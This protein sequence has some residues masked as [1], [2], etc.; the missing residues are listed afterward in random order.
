MQT[1][2]LTCLIGDEN[3]FRIE[4]FKLIAKL[5]MALDLNPVHKRTTQLSNKNRSMQYSTLKNEKQRER[6]RERE[7]ERL[8]T[9]KKFWMPQEILDGPKKGF[10]SSRTMI[11]TGLLLGLGF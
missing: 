10:R 6:E 7:R 4:T 3:P 8:K 2:I 9:P 5:P 1:I 11:K